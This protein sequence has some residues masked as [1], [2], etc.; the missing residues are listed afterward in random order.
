MKALLNLVVIAVFVGSTS[1]A[2]A[3]APSEFGNAKKAFEN[4]LSKIKGDTAGLNTCSANYVKSLEKLAQTMQMTGNLD[5]LMAASKEKERF[6]KEGS[7][8]ETP[9]PETPAELASVQNAYTK[10]LKSIEA[11]KAKKIAALVAPYMANLEEL[12]KRLT[13]NGAT[14]DAMEVKDEIDRVNNDPD[15]AAARTSTTG[16]EPEVQSIPTEKKQTT[17]PVPVAKEAKGST[18]TSVAPVKKGLVLYFPFDVASDKSTVDKGGRCSNGAVHGAKWSPKGKVG[19]CYI[20][21]GKSSYIATLSNDSIVPTTQFSIS[22]WVNNNKAAN[23]FVPIVLKNKNDSGYG[24]YA[25]NNE[26][27]IC[28]RVFNSGNIVLNFGDA[29]D[30]LACGKWAHVVVTFDSAFAAIIYKDGVEVARETPSAPAGKNTAKLYIGKR[31]DDRVGFNGMLDELMIF[32]R[33]LSKDEVA[34]IYEAQK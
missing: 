22:V 24:L 8:P 10:D 13:Q 32:D 9:G 33:A 14:D 20:F 6:L 26:S 21:D 31:E 17:T 7:A 12:K 30:S 25:D 34:Q 27:R 28:C 4:A 29:K 1:Y 16:K 19:G 2:V 15:I 3:Q 18:T 11:A 5:G 23:N